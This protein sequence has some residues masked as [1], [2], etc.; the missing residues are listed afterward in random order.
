M[1]KA[2]LSVALVAAAV[3]SCGVYDQMSTKGDLFAFNDSVD[4]TWKYYPSDE[5]IALPTSLYATD[6]TLIS[7]SHFEQSWVHT[8]DARTGK[9]ISN[10]VMVG[11][12]PD[13]IVFGT[14]VGETSQKRRYVLDSATRCLK[15]FN[16]DNIAEKTVNLNNTFSDIWD[17]WMLPNNKMVISAPTHDDINN[18]VKRN[19][20]I[21]DIATS[22]IIS[23]YDSIPKCVKDTPLAICMQSTGAVSPDGKHLAIGTSLGCVFEQFDINNNKL[24]PVTS[25]CVAIAAI[26]PSVSSDRTYW[27]TAMAATNKYVYGA[28]SGTTN[29]EEAYKIGVWDWTGKQIR[30]LKTNAA[31]VKMA[32]SPNGKRLYAVVAPKDDNP[33]LAYIDL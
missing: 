28:Y 4:V 21:Y 11:Q 6:T 17:A 1:N 9:L 3:S 19:L 5:V 31:I 7:L 10:A 26:T 8:F 18:S 12:G 29:S 14:K 24:Q 23:S 22:K 32:I 15:L 25:E 30:L 33:K 27:F 13:E 2:L 16:A 20:C